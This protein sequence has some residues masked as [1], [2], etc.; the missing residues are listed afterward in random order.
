MALEDWDHQTIREKQVIRM[1]PGLIRE[2]TPVQIR[3]LTRELT[4]VEIRNLNQIQ[5]SNCRLLFW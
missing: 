2:L 5:P 1:N 4:R 3:E